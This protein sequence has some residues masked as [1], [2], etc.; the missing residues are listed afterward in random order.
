MSRI[1]SALP[2]VGAVLLAA[3]A[4]AEEYTELRKK[5]AGQFPAL[6]KAR[7]KPTPSPWLV[8]VEFGNDLAYATKDGRLLVL[9]ELIDVETRTNLTQVD[10]E[11]LQ[12][13]ENKEVAKHLAGLREDTM[14]TMGPAKPKVTM[15]VFTDIDCTYCAR[16]H[17]DVP[18]LNRHGVRVR[19][20][21]FPRAG[22]GSDSYRKAVASWCA[23]DRV[24][25]V[26]LAK[27]GQ[28]I[29]MKTCANPVDDHMRLAERFGVSGTPTIFLD[30]GRRIGGYLPARQM[31]AYIGITP[32][33]QGAGR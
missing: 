12:A 8:Q 24:K 19:Y 3:P 22:A 32:A 6:A 21:F 16:F 13:S 26:G 31:L 30:N 28:P 18:E 5:L 2:I 29:E 9:G 27:A 23:D 7:I 17:L 20:L 25:A 15:T 10:R 14:I 4:H 33:G 1:L 11:R